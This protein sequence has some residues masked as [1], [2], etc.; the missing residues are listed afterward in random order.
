MTATTV[1]SPIY[2]SLLLLLLILALSLSLCLCVCCWYWY[3]Q[4]LRDELI[5]EELLADF[6]LFS[7]NQFQS[8]P[9]VKALGLT[10]PTDNLDFVLADIARQRGFLGREALPDRVCSTYAQHLPFNTTDLLT[11]SVDWRWGSFVRLDI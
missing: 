10:E 8:K 2:L 5:G 3:Q 11:R 4:A 1:Q 7:L 9:Y 6:L